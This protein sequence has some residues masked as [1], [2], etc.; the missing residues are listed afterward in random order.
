M[1]LHFANST[2]ILWNPLTFWGIHI[3][4]RNPEQLAVF[5]CCGIRNKINVATK[6]TL[7][8]V[9]RGIHETFVSGIHLHFGTCLKICLWNPRTYRH[10]T[11]R[12]SS[13]QFGFLM[14]DENHF[15]FLLFIV[16]IKVNKIECQF[17][18][19]NQAQLST[20]LINL[21][22]KHYVFQ[23]G[24][25]IIKQQLLL[26]RFFVFLQAT[27]LKKLGDIYHQFEYAVC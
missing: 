4:L 14:T 18:T 24:I 26:A 15:D 11:V 23:I 10:K 1:H 22:S 19:E 9:L 2:Y 13:A 20:I 16:R 17:Q 8:V 25:S 3:Q 27:E 5:A 21:F 6:F 7:Q 12:L